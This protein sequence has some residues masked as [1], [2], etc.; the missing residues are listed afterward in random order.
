VNSAEER[1]FCLAVDDMSKVLLGY[2]LS[3]EGGR[4]RRSPPP[5]EGTLGSRKIRC[6]PRR[7]PRVVLLS[8]VMVLSARDFHVH[9]IILINLGSHNIS[10]R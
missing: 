2:S 7:R 3:K 9:F 4:L 1:T 10:V 6:C 5:N 8:R